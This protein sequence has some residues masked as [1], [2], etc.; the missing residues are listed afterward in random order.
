[1][2]A[3]TLAMYLNQQQQQ[4]QQQQQTSRS[5][6][7]APVTTHT[8]SVT[9]SLASHTNTLHSSQHLNHRKL[10]D[11]SAAPVPKL[12]TPTINLKPLNGVDGSGGVRISSKGV[13]RN[14]ETSNHN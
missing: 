8:P 12:M 5:N 13:L 10:T 14:S 6:S 7:T 3:S 9:E 1:M 4:Q 11:S 2:H